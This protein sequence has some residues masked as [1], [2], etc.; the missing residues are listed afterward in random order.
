MSSS[1]ND[2]FVFLSDV[3]GSFDPVQFVEE[4]T[5]RI[6]SKQPLTESVGR[7]E[8]L[9]DGFQ[10][11]SSFLSSLANA[12]DKELDH[13]RRETETV[14][15]RHKEKMKDLDTTVAEVLKSFRRL[16]TRL[17]RVGRSALR[18]GET[19]EN[20]DQQRLR[21]IETRDLIQ[22]FVNLNMTSGAMSDNDLMINGLQLVHDD[23]DDDDALWNKAREISSRPLKG[24]G[25][26]GVD[27]RSLEKTR[28]SPSKSSRKTQER[29]LKKANSWDST[30]DED[31]VIG[32]SDHD[33]PKGRS[34]VT[35]KPQTSSANGYRHSAPTDRPSASRGS[36]SAASPAP[37]QK[38]ARKNSWDS[39]E[40][41]GDVL[42]T[43]VT[44]GAR[45]IRNQ[46]DVDAVAVQESSPAPQDRKGGRLAES[47]TF[48]KLQVNTSGSPV[49]PSSAWAS[50]PKGGR[51]LVRRNSWD[52]DDDDDD[53]DSP[54]VKK[55][56]SG[57]QVLSKRASA[58][59]AMPSPPSQPQRSGATATGNP[60]RPLVK[61]QSSWDDDDDDDGDDDD[62]DNN[63]GVGGG[64]GT[65]W[66]AELGSD[67]PGAQSRDR[68][69]AE[70][71]NG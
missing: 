53:D 37:G 70:P 39:D 27:V 42:D 31:L 2:S 43:R 7:I 68:T 63:V 28:P 32:D 5:K 20:A 18:I 49:A 46:D 33:S 64:G 54:K 3:Q 57:G 59:G 51:K 61:R 26:S 69:R 55:G 56:S 60:S 19:L 12:V 65:N 1:D 21:A 66:A 24:G 62:A 67:S 44:K 8:A 15:V 35:Q 11:T 6:V 4:V 10:S 52:S 41:D 9:R 38:L 48:K 14:E 16:E 34:P 13:L 40:S 22:H 23:D 17:N 58:G 47:R 45:G 29:V 71:R 30:D 36:R 25:E 50:S